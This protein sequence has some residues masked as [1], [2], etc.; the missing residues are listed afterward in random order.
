MSSATSKRQSAL[1]C[2]LMEVVLEVA[3]V[4][5]GAHEPQP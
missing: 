1:L 4:V 2:L 3:V 5:V